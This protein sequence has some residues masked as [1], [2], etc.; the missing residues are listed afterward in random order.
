MLD[1][2]FHPDIAN[3]WNDKVAKKSGLLD[4]YV[5]IAGVEI[6]GISATDPDHAK[7]QKLLDDKEF[8]PIKELI[9]SRV[10]HEVIP[11]SIPENA[12]PRLLSTVE[13]YLSYLKY[14]CNN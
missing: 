13:E 10:G 8:E 7:L 1:I 12:D 3:P 2:K 6:M 9:E 4:L 14:I 5:V 11:A